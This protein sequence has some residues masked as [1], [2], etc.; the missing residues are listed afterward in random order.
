[1]KPGLRIDQLMA[2]F[3]EG[4][5]ISHMALLLRDT[6][7]RWGCQSDIF[8]DPRHTSPSS[9]TQVRPLNEYRA[10]SADIA[11]HHYGLHAPAADVFFAS[12]ARKILIYHNITP[13][14]FYTG[15]DDQLPPQ[16]EAARQRLPKLARQTQA[17][18]AVSRFNA[19]ELAAVGVPDVKVLPLPF[20]P[21]TMNLTPDFRGAN[22]LFNTPLKT[23]L[24]VGRIAPNKRIEDLIQA[25]AWYNRT[26]NPYSRLVIVGSP[27]S[28]PRYCNMLK[29]LVGDLDMPNVCFEGFATPEGLIAYYRGASVYVSTSAH[30]GYGL[31]LLEAMYHGLPVIAR[32]TGGTP[33]ALD[34][35]GVL[36]EDLTHA[37]LAALVG[38]VLDDPALRTE[39]LTSQQHRLKSVLDR[40]IDQ[41]LRTLL[42]AFL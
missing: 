1:M 13:P 8:V 31:P 39:I 10:T 34:G 19:G 15:F 27:R 36:Y 25:F 4:D 35:A 42:A 38:V 28:C 21:H 20:V 16:L 7:R 6:F 23:W 17:V 12:P 11:L 9:L 41:E 3:A 29:M 33:E 30:E 2:G 24:S 22:F 37:E 5:A 26:L 14:S 18:W 40:P 32:A